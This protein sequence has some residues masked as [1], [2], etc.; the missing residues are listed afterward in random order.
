MGSSQEGSAVRICGKGKL[1]DFMRGDLR[2][3]CFFFLKQA[4]ERL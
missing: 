4:Y 1:K 2:V 3:F